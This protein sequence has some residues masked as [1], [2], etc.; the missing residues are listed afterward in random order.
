MPKY[1]KMLPQ[2]AIHVLK[3]MMMLERNFTDITARDVHD[4]LIE[5]GLGSNF[6]YVGVTVTYMKKEKLI[7]SEGT[8][9]ARLSRD[10][11]PINRSVLFITEYGR[12][13]YQKALVFEPEPRAA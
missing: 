8:T 4:W 5:I 12:E 2:R 7:R 11:D 1:V 10:I 3:A 6:N 9:S 13:R